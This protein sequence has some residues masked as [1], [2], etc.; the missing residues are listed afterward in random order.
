MSLDLQAPAPIEAREAAIPY[1]NTRN[2]ERRAARARLALRW[3]PALGIAAIAGLLLPRLLDYAQ[4][5]WQV[6]FFPW[7][8]DFDEGINANASWL[9]S[10]GVNIYRPNPP[11]HFIS[12]MYPPLYFALNAA[13]MKLWGLNL[14]SGRLIALIG[15]LGAGAM[16]W[17]WVYAETKRH[18]AGLF[19]AL[20]WF[21]LGPVYGWSTLYKQDMPALALGLAGGALVA[22][23]RGSGIGDRFAPGDQSP[24]PD[25]RPL[26]LAIIPL[27]LSFWIKQSSLVALGAVGLFLL[28]RD[29]RFALRWGAL[30]AASIVVPFVALDLLLKGGLRAHVLAFEHYGRSISQLSR[31]MEIFWNHHAPMLLGGLAFAGL[32]IRRAVAR[33]EAPPLS[34]IYLLVAVPATLLGNT[35]PTANFNHLLDLLAPLCLVLGVAL[36]TAWNG[37]H[38]PGER[39]DW[40]WV[41][42]GVLLLALAQTGMTY[43]KPSWAWYSDV[44][45]T[46]PQRAAQLEKLSQTIRQTPGDVLSED[47]WLLLKNGKRVIYDDPAAM[48]ALATAGAW[49]QSVLLQ[50]L[51]RRK[52]SL[53]VLQY[54]LTNVKKNARWSAQGLQALQSN[55]EVLF[56][57]VVTFFVPRPPGPAPETAAACAVEGGPGLEGYTYRAAT[58]NRGDAPLLSLYWRGAGGE[59]PGS[60]FFVRLIDGAGTA[61]WGADLVPGE[62]AGKPLNAGWGEGEAVRDDLPVTIPADLPEGKYRLILGMYRLGANGQI[63]PAA[64]SCERGRTEADGTFILSDVE[65]VARWGK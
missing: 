18:A 21:S 60:K 29:W 61:K 2:A 13:A 11:D 53:V 63:V 42:V 27:S 52:F 55:Y 5:S 43:G 47:N 41:A 45:M 58:A 34:L 16:L 14:W 1:T 44:E 50:D 3:L 17:A 22:R 33:R 9:L 30:A 24:F 20:L 6:I 39:A 40:A 59:D 36:G 4:H 48:A 31:N 54:D 8:L 57:D 46:L 37:L 12:S 56:R 49:D 10:Q 65:V 64:L 26:Y 35:L 32:G 62:P 23:G 19:A 51:E 28:L 25:H 15:A 7:Q 38:V